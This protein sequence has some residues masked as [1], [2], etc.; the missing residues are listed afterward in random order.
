MQYLAVILGGGVVR[1]IISKVWPRNW[2]LPGQEEMRFRDIVFVV[3]AYFVLAIVVTIITAGIVVAMRP[4]SDRLDGAGIKELLILIITNI[5]LIGVIVRICG[6]DDVRNH[7]IPSKHQVK[8]DILVGIAGA[9]LIYIAQR[10][11]FLLMGLISSD[12]GK[13]SFERSI[14]GGNVTDA[15]LPLFFC[16]VVIGPLA[17]ELM[18][19]AVLHRTLVQ[20]FN[21][22]IAIIASGLVFA[23]VHGDGLYTPMLWVTGM[24]LA[25][26]YHR[27]QSL[28]GPIVAHAANNL[29]GFLVLILAS[30]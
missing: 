4:Y 10:P 11:V 16:M 27:S 21:P 19:R 13:Q 8:G 1:A 22:S 23:I 5:G 2:K 30:A 25:I 24:G 15:I 18:F 12:L 17:E 7:L 3:I 29:V 9:L 20:R 26:V 14:S 6:W 28:L